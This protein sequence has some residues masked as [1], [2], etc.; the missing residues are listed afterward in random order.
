MMRLIYSPVLFL[1]L[2]FA[3]GQTQTSN[4]SSYIIRSLKSAKDTTD[5]Y[6]LK[7]KLGK[8]Y[9]QYRSYFA[10]VPSVNPLNPKK[11]RRFSSKFGRRFHPKDG[12]YEQHLGLDIS[13]K[14]GTPVH[15]AADGKII[16][17]N[18][19]NSGCGNSVKIAHL[20]GFTTRYCHMYTFIV[21]KGQSV[22][23]GDIIG[24]VGSTGHSTGPHLHYEVKKNGVLVDPY[25]YC[26]LSL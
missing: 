25:P 13:S 21:K 22:K 8:E 12:K 26:F 11:L 18:R 20:Y 6:N 10:Y 1:V 19:S 7:Q 3:V 16:V 2:S 14:T 4:K 9:H 5:I 23:K 17:T 24:F 15:A